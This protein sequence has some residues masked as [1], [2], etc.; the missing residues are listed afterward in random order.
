[1]AVTTSKTREFQA[2]R[3]A[4]A[5]FPLLLVSTMLAR[6]GSA[7]AISGAEDEINVKDLGAIGDGR[8]HRI[9]EWIVS[10]RFASLSALK[11]AYPSVASLDDLIDHVVLNM[12]IQRGALSR[13]T[14]RIPAGTYRAFLKI[15]F[16]NVRIVG[17]GS[18]CTTIRLPDGAVHTVP[19]E[20]S[21]QFSTGVPCVVD[22]NNIGLGNVSAALVDGHISGVTVDG[23][24]NRTAVP[25]TD[26]HGWGISFTRYNRV[27]YHDIR[28]VN[29]HLGGIGTFIDSNH[30][31]GSAV[32]SNC[33]H[34]QVEGDGR[35]GFDVNSSSHG[36]WKVE[37]YDC[38]QGARLLDNC[39]GNRLEV[40][41]KDAV[42]IGM[43][44]DN[45]PVNASRENIVMLTVNRGCKIAGLLVGPHFRSSYFT[46]EI[47]NVRGVGVHTAPNSSAI[48]G[49]GNMFR[50]VTRNCGAQGVLIEG[51]G[52]RFVIESTEDGRQGG[53]GAFF[54]VDII[55]TKNVVSAKMI[56]KAPWKVRGIALRKAARGNHIESF[57][58]FNIVDQLLVE[59]SANRISSGDVPRTKLP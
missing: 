41:V 22:F 44:A 25:L 21:G 42:Q 55:G 20:G 53:Q 35:P 40:T 6:S 37:V 49:H 9:R 24:R 5:S 27:T 47:S 31:D 58:A 33:G 3:A 54:A 59:N 15:P 57:T 51:S 38:W 45:Q 29:C 36:H 50:V 56:D 8:E 13:R 12:A 7:T 17:D 16:S 34:S 4:L 18:D 10:G 43:I 26:L 39:A 32:V 23:N 46:T 48:A 14:V 30:H 11:E 1:M 28:A 19:I 2:R 52:D